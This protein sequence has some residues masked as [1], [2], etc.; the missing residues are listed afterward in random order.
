MFPIKAIPV[1]QPARIYWNEY[2][3]PFIEAHDDLDLALLLGA[4]LVTGIGMVSGAYGKDFMGV[5][6]ISLAF[7]IPLMIPAFGALFPGSAA[8]WIQAL[9]KVLGDM[10]RW[11]YWRARALEAQGE[12]EQAGLIY[13]AL[14]GERSYH[15]FLAAD[16]IGRAASESRPRR[17]RRR[18]D[19][20]PRP[21]RA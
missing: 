21:I 10:E 5:M 18:G 14:A 9:P 8:A 15:G 16:R 2:Q 3:V 12:A 19:R 6:F 11:R 4:V 20:D 13:H 17:P 7:M 1:R